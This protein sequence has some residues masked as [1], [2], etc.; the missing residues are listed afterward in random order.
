M[1]II[2]HERGGTLYFVSRSEDGKLE[3]ILGSSSV[4]V[5]MQSESR[6][7]SI[8]GTAR[9]VSDQL[10]ADELWSESM[11]IWFPEGASDQN[12]TIIHVEPCY[13]EFWDRSGLR[14]LEFLWEAGKAL[15]TAR[16]ASDEDL[17]GHAKVR[18]Q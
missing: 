1:A 10:L 4:A 9:I 15:V 8:S 6:Y 16:K 14:Q 13:A 17:S 5:T 11:R 7:L 2:K 12:L 18:M 3:E